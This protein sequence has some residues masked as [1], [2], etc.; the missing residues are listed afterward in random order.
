MSAI[1][2]YCSLA[3]YLFIQYIEVINHT[4]ACVFSLMQSNLYA[5]PAIP[6]CPGSVCRADHV[7]SE[8]KGK[9]KG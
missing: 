6:Y 1:A 3:L 4:V 8:I 2:V 5:V 7:Q 9:A